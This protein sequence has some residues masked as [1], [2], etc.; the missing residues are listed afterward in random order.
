VVEVWRV[1]VRVVLSG[2]L[3]DGSHAVLLYAPWF[4]VFGIHEY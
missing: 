3:R 2:I 4:G 1:F